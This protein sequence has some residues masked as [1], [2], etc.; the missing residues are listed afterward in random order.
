MTQVILVCANVPRAGKGT[1]GKFLESYLTDMGKEVY[2][3]EFKDKL[4]E[5][6]ADI[7]GI[8]VEEFLE[9]YD[10]TS[11]DYRNQF[12]KQ[13]LLEKYDVMT[14]VHSGYIDWWKDVKMYKVGDKTYSKR[15]WLQHVSE[16]VIK[17]HTSS[18]FFGEAT[19]KD[20]PYGVGFV[21]VTDSGFASE[22]VP[23]IEAYGRDNVT[24]VQLIRDVESSVKDTRKMLEPSD[25]EDTL[26]PSFITIH[27]KEVDNW[28]ELLENN[29]QVLAD[30]LLSKEP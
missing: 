4:F 3:A 29:L 13:Q 14:V 11:E 1:S 5:V 9:G 8:S 20:I 15:T 2:V 24:V 28:Q 27:N 19:L 26:R 18:R 17:P 6:S 21:V 22:A 25:F 30:N 12:T 7:L 10:Q 23:L 16:K